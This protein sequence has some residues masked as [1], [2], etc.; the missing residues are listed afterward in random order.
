MPD[1]RFPRKGTWN[2]TGPLQLK[3][4]QRAEETCS[5]ENGGQALYKA[6]Q[7]LYKT[8]AF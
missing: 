1:L 6:L 8:K 5:V 3:G 7:V 4:L 2:Y